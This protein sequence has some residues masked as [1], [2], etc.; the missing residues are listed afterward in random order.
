MHEG[1]GYKMMVYQPEREM[2]LGRPRDRRQ[3]NL[4]I[5]V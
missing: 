5:K 2:P 3:G 1:D 4:R